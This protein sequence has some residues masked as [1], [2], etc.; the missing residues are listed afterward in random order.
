MRNLLLI[1]LGGVLCLLF[2]LSL[3]G[4]QMWKHPLG[5]VTNQDY[6][7]IQVSD[8]QSHQFELKKGESKLLPYGD[9][10]VVIPE[11]KATFYLFKNNRGVC[12]IRSANGILIV[13]LNENASVSKDPQ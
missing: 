7:T 9:Y 4:Y 8:R 10:K 5:A 6:P 11:S 1:G 13:E 12:N 2:G 3:R